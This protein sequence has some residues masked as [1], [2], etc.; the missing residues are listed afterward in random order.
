MIQMDQEKA[1]P[2]LGLTDYTEKKGFAYIPDLLLK[3]KPRARRGEVI[4][5]VTLMGQ[6]GGWWVR[7]PVTSSTHR[8]SDGER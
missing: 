2:E 8:A 6:P 5:R 1:P 4:K 3:R 7:H